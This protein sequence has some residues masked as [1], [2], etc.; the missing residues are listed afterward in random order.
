MG[1]SRWEQGGAWALREG[2]KVGPQLP[3]NRGS[4]EAS[5]VPSLVQD[6]QAD[7]PA[8][9]QGPRGQQETEPG[10]TWPPASPSPEGPLGSCHIPV[11]H[12]QQGPLVVWGLWPSQGHH[13]DLSQVI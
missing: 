5:A 4:A 8:L 11:V 9:A 1:H 13:R 7:T 3:P 10:P 2:P 12:S 6:P